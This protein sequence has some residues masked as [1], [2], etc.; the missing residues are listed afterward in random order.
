MWSFRIKLRFIA[1]GCDDVEA[2]PQE[3]CDNKA[4]CLR[5]TDWNAN[6]SHTFKYRDTAS[7]YVELEWETDPGN[8]FTRQ[9]GLSLA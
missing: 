4:S 1:G 2:I 6:L 3:F 7:L 8:V 9:L 5:D